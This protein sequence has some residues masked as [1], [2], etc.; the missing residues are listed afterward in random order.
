MNQGTDWARLGMWTCVLL[1]N[2]LAW[3][4]LA[5][6]VGVAVGR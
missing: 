6:A 3:Y 2:M 1:G 4:V 5:W